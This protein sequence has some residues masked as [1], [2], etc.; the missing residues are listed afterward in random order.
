ML[1]RSIDTQ[2]DV[3]TILE[4][5]RPVQATR[6]RVTGVRM[7]GRSYSPAGTYFELIGMGNIVVDMS[8]A[9]WRLTQ[10]WVAE[11][12]ETQLARR[13]GSMS[14]SDLR[15]SVTL[16]DT[17]TLSSEDLKHQSGIAMQVANPTQ[18]WVEDLRRNA[19]FGRRE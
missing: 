7:G 13:A 19:A 2:T 5:G 10:A 9:G 8:T 3:R 16:N 17:V 6:V 18:G 1:F 11:Q 14:F 4:G 15:W 12:L